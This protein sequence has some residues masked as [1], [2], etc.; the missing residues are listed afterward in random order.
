MCTQRSPYNW[1]EQLYERHSYSITE[2]LQNKVLPVLKDR[3]G[4]FLLRELVH[5]NSNHSVM[6]LWHQK[7][8]QYLD[9]YYVKY[10]AKPLLKDAG[11]KL[12]KNIIFDVLKRDVANALLDLINQER[13]A[14]VV[15]RTLMKGAVQPF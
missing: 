6:N 1:S 14:P 12:F 13:D 10:H 11:L 7:F 15:D 2:Y 8:F 3:H 9:R 4:E 5:R